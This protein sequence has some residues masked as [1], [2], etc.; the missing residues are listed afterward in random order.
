MRSEEPDTAAVNGPPLCPGSG[1]EASLVELLRERD[2]RRLSEVGL[3]EPRQR[4]LREEGRVHEVGRR[5]LHHLLE[6]A[7]ALL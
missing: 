2:Q 1:G 6:G 4:D 3:L 7:A 5:A